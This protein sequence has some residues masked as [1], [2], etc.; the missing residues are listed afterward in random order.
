M[1]R[2]WL[3]KGVWT[4]EGRQMYGTRCSLAGWFGTGNRRN[5]SSDY[6]FTEVR[7]LSLQLWETGRQC[8]REEERKG[9]SRSPGGQ[10][11][12]GPLEWGS[13]VEGRAVSVVCVRFSALG[14]CRLW[15][16]LD[17][18]RIAVLERVSW[19]VSEWWTWI[20]VWK[21]FGRE[22]CYQLKKNLAMPSNRHI[23]GVINLTVKF[24]VS[25]L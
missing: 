7:L 24:V 8:S 16:G 5:F 22:Q 9:V 10:T 14:V 23:M 20:R 2:C 17:W 6:L 3:L 11:G 13:S 21:R 12:W 19:K 18:T 15:G 25:T 4:V 1:R